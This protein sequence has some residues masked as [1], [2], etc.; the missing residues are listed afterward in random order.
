MRKPLWS[1][2]VLALVLVLAAGCTAAAPASAPAA[3]SG[4]P[5]QAAD[6]STDAGAAG[7]LI[8][9]RVSTVSEPS[10]LDPNLAEDAY[11]ITPV[12]QLFLGFDQSQQ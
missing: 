3:D 4:T 1:V 6:T 5:E 9:V 2:L 7:D 10:T 12:E 8:T 11:S